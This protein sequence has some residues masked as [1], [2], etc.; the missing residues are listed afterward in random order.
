[1]VLG[2]SPRTFAAADAQ[3]LLSPVAHDFGRD[4]ANGAKCRAHASVHA[5]R[6]ASTARRRALLRAARTARG[7]LSRTDGTRVGLKRASRRGYVS[8]FILRDTHQ[9]AMPARD[10]RIPRTPST[11]TAV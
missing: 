11:N 6:R 10:T 3:D 4:R 2:C 7:P 1:A 8:R 5:F 9:N